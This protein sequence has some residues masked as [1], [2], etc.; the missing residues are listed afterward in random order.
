MEGFEE[1]KNISNLTEFVYQINGRSS[2]DLAKE[3]DFD[4]FEEEIIRRTFCPIITLYEI[5][6]DS[7]IAKTIDF[8]EIYRFVS[9]EFALRSVAGRPAAFL[10]PRFCGFVDCR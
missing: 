3:F 2:D 4:E 7:I 5:D 6:V 9:S 8:K 10:A 1:K